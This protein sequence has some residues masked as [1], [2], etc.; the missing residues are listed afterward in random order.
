MKVP[1]EKI[2][3]IREATDIVDLVSRFVT[4]KKRGK[5]YVGLCPFHT[6]KTPS[7]SVDP[8]RGFYHCFG[9]GV[10]GNVFTFVMQM[11]KV[12]FPEA[13]RSLAMKAGIPLPVAEEDDG[14]AKDE[15][16]LYHVN[17]EVSDFYR[18]CLYETDAG[19]KALVYFTDR[20]FDR[21]TIDKFQIGYAPNRWDGLQKLAERV[22]MELGSL[23]K[24][25]L[26]VRRK[27]GE[28]YYDRF[29]GR[30]MFP[31]LNASGRVV[32]FGGRVLKEEAGVPKYINSAETPI[33]QK[34]RLLY[35]LFQS[36][37]GI[38]REDRVLL[39][40][41]YTDLMRL[42]QCKLDY[43]VATSGTALTEDQAN[44][45]ARYTKNVT[46]V[47]DGDSAGF[48]AALRGVDVLVGAGLNVEIVRLPA[49]SDPDSVLHTQGAEGLRGL[50]TKALTFID[51]YFQRAQEKKKLNTP[52]DR[53]EAARSILETVDRIKDPLVRNLM[54][55]DVADKFGVEEKFLI[56]QI[57]RMQKKGDV[58]N[59]EPETRSAS[60]REAAEE[61][62]VLLLLE[63]LARWGKVIFQHLHIDDVR[64]RN[65]RPIVEG[66]Y[67]DFMKGSVPEAGLL[68]DRHSDD[69][70]VV[71]YLS[72]LLSEGMDDSVDRSQFGLDCLLNVLQEETQGKI[73][74]IRE[75]IRSAQNRGE[76]VAGYSNEWM[77]CQCR[78]VRL[79]DE[80]NRAW[81]KNVEI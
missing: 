28:G 21:D 22:S 75:K 1:E 23:M 15:E 78:L 74:Q 76:D 63:D 33:Y 43:G 24:A 7:F 57:R 20:G 51:F 36:A 3:E 65:V 77:E 42:H 5:S 60:G 81:K 32:G 39:V 27:E 58:E 59:R 79:K 46:L 2:Q 69:I 66:L 62:L 80:V 26:I 67:E 14:R 52:H 12:S 48:S 25:G 56:L 6:E 44:L 37:S 17:Q 18:R 54:I 38:R 11:D 34:G 68:L 16:L 13:V 40:E 64:G 47:F 55:K 41:G 10:G 53:A 31:V 49:G 8:V 29:R 30:L 71:R 4:L 61:G 35:G 73:Q 50:L 70:H 72:K 19:E 9:C 45:I